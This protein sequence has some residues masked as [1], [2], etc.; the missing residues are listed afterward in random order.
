MGNLYEDALPPAT[1]ERFDTLLSHR[2]L[3]IERIVSTAKIASQEYVQEQDE[4]VV[5]LTGEAMLD[6][7]GSKVALKA[8]DYLFLPA[9]TPHAV[10]Q[11]SDGALWLAVH[12]HGRSA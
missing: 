6:V 3:V 12:L 2:G 9:R 10:L 8:G 1:G 11:V 4:W 5:L 7:A